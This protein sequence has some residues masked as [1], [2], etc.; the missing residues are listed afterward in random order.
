M[1]IFDS[2][3]DGGNNL[4]PLYYRMLQLLS[5]VLNTIMVK[6]DDEEVPYKV[7][8]PQYQN[9]KSESGFVQKNFNLIQCCPSGNCSC[10]SFLFVASVFLYGQKT[11]V[12]HFKILSEM[13]TSNKIT[14]EIL[15]LLS[16]CIRKISM[17]S[18]SESGVLLTKEN[19]YN[20]YSFKLKLRLKKIIN[21]LRQKYKISEYRDT[22]ITFSIGVNSIDYD[23]DLNSYVLFKFLNYDITEESSEDQSKFFPKVYEEFNTI[24]QK[25]KSV[26]TKDSCKIWIG[27]YNG[28]GQISIKIIL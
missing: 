10:W 6:F 19:I 23:A 26:A 1:H 9:Y 22:P 12:E 24:L 14:Y 16:E 17:I 7:K 8:I 2:N 15:D 5:K 3:G 27:N 21:Q 20:T 28:N 11:T 25:N 4:W 13:S 18:N